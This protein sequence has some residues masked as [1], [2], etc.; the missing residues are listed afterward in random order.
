M[1]LRCDSSNIQIS[2]VRS[3]FNQLDLGDINV[4]EF[5]NKREIIKGCGNIPLEES[6]YI[7]ITKKLQN[8]VTSLM[9]GEACSAVPVYKKKK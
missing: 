8:S 7:A 1:E 4:K 3:S 5:Q 6:L 9:F 2:D